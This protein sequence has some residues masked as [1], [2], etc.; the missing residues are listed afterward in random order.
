VKHPGAVA[1]LDEDVAEDGTAFL[2]MELLHGQ[3]VETLWQRCADRLP[4]KL[5]TGVAVQLLDVLA[6][7]HG[8]GVIHRDIKPENLLVTREGQVKV[9]DFGI[10]RVRDLAAGRSTQTGLTMG[11]PAY[12][13][14]EH[15]R[16]KPEEIDARTDLWAVGATIF[17]LASGKTVHA[18]ENAQALLVVAA[19]MRARPLA[20]VLPDAPK[21]FC[22]I[23]DRALEFDRAHRW[24]DAK[25]M[26]D[27]LLAAWAECFG[28]APTPA[29]L[30]EH[31]R[32]LGVASMRPPAPQSVH[33]DARTLPA[34]PSAAS[35]HALSPSLPGPTTAEP[36][37][38]SPG[39]HA[40]FPVRRASRRT[41]VTFGAAG[42]ALAATLIAALVAR[43]RSS[44]QGSANGTT[45][46][47][48]PA[49]WPAQ[50]AAPPDSVGA[51]TVAA[52]AAPAAVR[53][54]DL[55]APTAS[56]P[57]TAKPRPASPTK[58]SCTPP[59]ELDASGNKRW[60]RECL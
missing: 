51:G 36:V 42:A 34:R 40:G 2:V 23:V 26:R 8:R 54:E 12:M 27:A 60:K 22:R 47:A 53:V 49:P 32:E 46:H 28:E 57:P 29:M 17:T 52:S 31:F 45:A 24:P 41:L 55:P 39:I 43:G 30:A 1:V 33:P 3:T 16:A 18:A 6:A 50:A 5:V 21:A 15:A 25:A 56:T 48:D 35:G 58:R 14:P 4:L 38:T 20:E 7:A 9:L 13:S 19:T 44:D 10:A 59:Y 11:T 37:D